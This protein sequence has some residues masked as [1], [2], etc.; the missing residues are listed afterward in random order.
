[1]STTELSGKLEC[2]AR[3]RQLLA[4][5]R[6]RQRL[7]AEDPVALEIPDRLKGDVEAPFGDELV[8]RHQLVRRGQGCRGADLIE[9]DDR[10]S[11]HPLGLISGSVGLLAQHHSVA[12]RGRRH[13]KADAQVDARKLG[14]DS[15]ERSL[16]CL[17]GA[18]CTGS[19]QDDGEL[20]APQAEAFVRGAHVGQDGSDVGQHAVAVLVP[21]L[22]VVQLE[23]VDVDERQDERVAV[24]ARGF[25]FDRETLLV[26]GVVSHTG[27]RVA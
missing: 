22:V 13:G 26:G 12:S 27:E 21:E 17:L 6:A 9:D 3:A 11:F 14:G 19:R 24:A 5:A 20:V 7:I 4:L 25:P 8:K 10:A 15:L 16:H 18:A 1:M 23:F 2:F